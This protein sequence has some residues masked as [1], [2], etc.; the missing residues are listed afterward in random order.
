MLRLLV[1]I[2]LALAACGQKT[3]TL[4]LVNRTPRKIVELYVYP[5]GSSNQGASRGTIAPNGTLTLKLPIGHLE[6]R[7]VSE[8]FQ[9]DDKTNETR[10]ASTALQLKKT[11]IDVVF[12]DSNAPA[13]GLDKP[14]TIGVAFR[15]SADEGKSTE[16]TEPTEPTVEPTAPAP[17]P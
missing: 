17:A 14:N 1:V 9:V 15:V 5:I 10:E 3:Q 13:P 7:A 11:P 8:R 6:V 12:H 16:S 4:N 2:V